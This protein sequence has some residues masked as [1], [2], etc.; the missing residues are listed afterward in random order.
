MIFNYNSK[1]NVTLC[2]QQK[3]PCNKKCSFWFYLHLTTT[4]QVYNNPG[5]D[6]I[7]KYNDRDIFLKSKTK[8][9]KRHSLK[10]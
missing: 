4:K 6:K 5:N 1:K 8:I 7:S 2:T 3:L 10:F 9:A